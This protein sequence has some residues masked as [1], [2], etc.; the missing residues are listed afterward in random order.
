MGRILI[1]CHDPHL[2]RLLAA[3]L[4]YDSHT[5]VQA[6]DVSEARK[7]ISADDYDCVFIP[8][9]LPGAGAF[10]I[11]VAALAPKPAT[12]IVAT[13]APSS[14][15]IVLT[16]L[17][18]A[19]FQVLTEPFVAAQIRTVAQRACERSVLVRENAQLRRIV[20]C[21]QKE[22]SQLS[23]PP[24]DG[25]NHNNNLLRAHAPALDDGKEQPNTAGFVTPDL[26]S[27][28][29]TQVLDQIE[30]ELIQKVLSH[31]GGLQAEAARR[32]GLSRSAL[33]YKLHK[34]GIRRKPAQ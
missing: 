26:A 17:G 34:Y 12:S 5:L 33:A 10:E 1:A 16:R 3:S 28:N 7:K 14:F 20:S 27:F 2:R 22:L 21:I 13:A 11:I 23:S 9:E 25:S 4:L 18:N 29:L 8:A 19:I 31:V 15:E 32:M 6:K 24:S 30:E